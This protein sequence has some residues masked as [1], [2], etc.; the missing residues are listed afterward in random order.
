MRVAILGVSGYTGEVLLKLLLSHPKIEEIIPVSRSFPDKD[1]YDL[2]GVVSKDKL[3]STKGRTTNM[4]FAIKSNPDVVFSALPHLISAK[5]CNH[6]FGKSLVIDLSA[7]F[8]L[9]DKELFLKA[10]GSSIPRDDILDQSAYGLS[11]WNRKQIKKMNIIANPGCYP[12]CFLLAILPFA[13]KALI[14]KRIIVNALS[15]ISGAGKKLSED[16]LYCQSTENTHCYLPGKQHRHLVE[17]EEYT[18]KFADFKS[19]IIFAPHL[20]P[21]KQGM[22]LTIYTR[23]TEKISGIDVDRILRDSYKNSIFVNITCKLPQTSNVQNTN[24]CD[25]GFHLEGKTL[26]LFSAIDNLYKGASS[27][28]IQNMNIHYG[29]DETL[30]IPLN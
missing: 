7:D 28:A 24:R 21:Q 19:D 4:D 2:F 15:G 26:I 8:R 20:I 17:M 12:A 18:K 6:F 9:K 23:L 10:Y 27:A 1:I 13:K 16:L 14:K 3:K 25:I 11:E 22:F 30:G 29:F 5:V